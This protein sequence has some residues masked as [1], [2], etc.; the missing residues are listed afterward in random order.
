VWVGSLLVASVAVAAIAARPLADQLGADFTHRPYF[1]GAIAWG[2]ATVVAGLVIA[3]IRSPRARMRLAAALVAADA[4]LLFAVPEAAAPRAIQTDLTPVAFLQ[5]NLGLSRAVTLGPLQPNYG[6]YFGIGLLNV[7]DV[8][9]PSAFSRYVHTRLDQAV[10]PTVFSGNLGGRPFGSPT[11]QQELLRNLAGYRAA[12]VKYVL[13]PAGQQLP[14]PNFT[15][16]DRGPSTWIYRLAGSAPYF[17]ASDPRCTVTPEGRTAV[18]VACP[19]PAQLVRRET[20]LPGWSAEVDG[21]AVPVA[22]ADGLFQTVAVGQGSHRV[23][24][25]YAPPNVGWGA[26]AFIAGLVLLVL[27]AIGPERVRRLAGRRG[28]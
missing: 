4:V 1:A 19:G 10:D 2:L 7:I 20:D 15:L 6:S 21:R 14:S 12:G 5:R 8:P 13:T 26:I 25:S 22:R 24:Y 11:P 28:G 16:V 18:R 27:G 23:T 17:T 9:I 3:A